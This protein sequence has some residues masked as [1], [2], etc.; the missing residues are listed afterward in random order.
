MARV[1]TLDESALPLAPARLRNCA[2]TPGGTQSFP[3]FG[4]GLGKRLKSENV[5]PSHPTRSIK[6]KALIKNSSQK[7]FLYS[8][9]T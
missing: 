6:A 8:A 3:R 5:G 1:G 4:K 7:R 2:G 9:V